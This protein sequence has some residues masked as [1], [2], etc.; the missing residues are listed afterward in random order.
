M[1]VRGA[2]RIRFPQQDVVPVQCERPGPCEPGVELPQ[3]AGGGVSRVL[4][5]LLPVGGE[6][7]VHAVE[8]GDREHRL[9]PHREPFGHALAG[10]PQRQRPYRAEVRG[11][12]LTDPPVAAGRSADEHACLVDELHGESVV[13]GLQ[14]VLDRFP[15]DLTLHALAELAQI[16]L[17]MDAVEG[18]ERRDVLHLGEGVG[19]PTPDPPG[20]GIRGRQRRVRPFEVFQLTEQAVVVGVLDLGVVEHVVTVIVVADPLGEVR[21]T[22][23]GAGRNDRWGRRHFTGSTSLGPLHGAPV[24]EMTA[25]R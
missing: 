20:G 16:G 7:A 8:V 11:D 25:A 18:Q 22:R 14:G 15:P 23:P 2:A 19:N 9:A 4:E 13:L 5:R 10:E 24:H 12:V 21:V 17:V 6:R 3:R 1:G